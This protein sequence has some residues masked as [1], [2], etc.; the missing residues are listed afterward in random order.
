MNFRPAVR[1]KARRQASAQTLGERLANRERER[2]SF[3]RSSGSG[4][5]AMRVSAQTRSQTL[6]AKDMDVVSLRMT[7]SVV[8]SRRMVICVKRQKKNCSSLLPVRSNQDLA[9]SEWRCRLQISASHT[10]ESGKFNVFIDLFVGQVDLGTSGDDQGERHSFRARALALEEHGLNTR[11][12]QFAYRA[13]VRG[14]LRLQLSIQRC[15]NV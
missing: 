15:W 2:N 11:Q 13:P 5:K 6:Q 8:R 10:L 12:D 9:L 3:S 1:A 14:G 7:A 4:R